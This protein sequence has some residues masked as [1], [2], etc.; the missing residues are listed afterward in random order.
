MSAASAA[1]AVRAVVA[2]RAAQR[3]W[4]R[5]RGARRPGGRCEPL[6][7]RHAGR[8]LVG[9]RREPGSGRRK[10][11]RECRRRCRWRPG[12]RHRRLAR[13][14]SGGRV[15]RHCAAFGFVAFFA[16]RGRP[17]GRAI[18]D[19]ADAA[20]RDAGR[21]IATSCPACAFAAANGAAGRDR[22]AR[23]AGLCTIVCVHGAGRQRPGRR[24]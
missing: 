16:R 9:V 15:G 2:A 20:I 18:G 12:R 3:A 22:L 14:G 17:A 1:D 4:R 19:A 7:E 8:V 23:L 6:R 21:P 11:R 24:T 5:S 13:Q 10:R